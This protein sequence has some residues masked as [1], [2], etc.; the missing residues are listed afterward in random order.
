[1]STAGAD[2]ANKT[3]PLPWI[4]TALLTLSALWSRPLLPID[5]TRY[6]SV[7]WEMRQQGDYLVSHLNGETYAHKP[8]LLFW[9]INAVWSITGVHEITGRLV[10]PVLSLCS[11]LLTRRMAQLIWKGNAAAAESAAV[12]H[13]SCML[14]MLL[15][16]LTMFDVL[17]TVCVQISLL[18]LLQMEQSVSA[19][20]PQRRMKYVPLIPGTLMLGLGM[21]LGILSKGPVILLHVLPVSVL[22][23]VWSDRVRTHSGRWFL[24]LGCAIGIAAAAGLS[25]AVPSAISGGKAYAE[26]LLW[27]QT[28]NRMVNS[29]AHREPWWWYLVVAPLIV[30]PWFSISALWRRDSETRSAPYARFLMIWMTG[31][32]ILLSLISG[33][34]LHYLLPVVPCA[35]LLVAHRLTRQGISIIPSDLNFVIYGTT[36]GGLLPLVC[37]LFPGLSGGRLTGVC[38]SWLSVPLCLCGLNLLALR[39]FSARN[40]IRRVGTSSVCFIAVL[41]AGLSL[42]FWPGFDVA[43]LAIYVREQQ[44]KHS[45]V[46]WYGNYPGTLNFSGR[47]QSP[48]T[49]LSSVEALRQWLKSHPD[50]LVVLPISDPEIPVNP[51]FRTPLTSEELQRVVLSLNSENS[52]D[53]TPLKHQLKYGCWIRRGLTTGLLVVAQ[54]DEA[55]TPS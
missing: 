17:L 22:G 55:E 42:N 41:V 51:D 27:G 7:A 43:R 48:I 47:L 2:S 46:A 5:E 19:P 49:E 18:G 40:V 13:C 23:F 50:G 54:F 37:N 20:T 33:K 8:P 30:L 24:K 28:A 6:L 1:M 52:R 29:F 35:A 14:W 45:S 36:V 21:G 39:D 38:P 12:I 53:Q 34:Q 9:L 11:V 44:T 4:L 3:D 16:Q 25:W 32:L 26:E 31:T 10:V 15:S